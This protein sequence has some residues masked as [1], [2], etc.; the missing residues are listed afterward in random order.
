MLRERQKQM[1]GVDLE[2]ARGLGIIG[3]GQ[4]PLLR[5]FAFLGGFVCIWDVRMFS[6]RFFSFSCCLFSFPV[7]VLFVCFFSKF[8]FMF[9]CC[10]C[11]LIYFSV[12]SFF[13][14]WLAYHF[15]LVV[16]HLLGLAHSLLLFKLN[17]SVWVSSLFYNPSSRWG[18]LPRMPQKKAI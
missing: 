7:F 12:W 13:V 11:F 15:Q 5:P 8:Q 16:D 2:P 10:C 4:T 1:C 14:S 3:F 6:V 9:Y 18:S 17:R